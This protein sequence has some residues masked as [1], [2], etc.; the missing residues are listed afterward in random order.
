MMTET[1][2]QLIYTIIKAPSRNALIGQVNE[3]IADNW[4]PMS[5]AIFN[6][7]G[8]WYQTMVNELVIE[9]K[10]DDNGDAGD[11]EDDS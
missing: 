4:M 7:Q 8:Q 10:G 2:T 6:S 5:G 11:T 3:A 9:I 1:Q